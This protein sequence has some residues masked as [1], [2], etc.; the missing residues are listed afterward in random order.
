MLKFF[1]RNEEKDS[2]KTA[3]AVQKSR[4]TWFGKMATLFSRTELDAAAWDELEELLISADVG[5][6]TTFKL[7]ETLRTRIAEE[8]LTDPTEV[9]EALKDEMIYLVDFEDAAETLEAQEKPLVILMVGVNGVGKTTSIAKLTQLYK[10]SGKSVILGAAD[11][12]RAAAIEQLQVWA[13]RLG[14]DLIAHQ[15][16][17]DPGAVAFDTINAAMARGT[18]VVIIDTAGRLHTKFNLMEELKKIQ[19]IMERQ[20]V[21]SHRVLV[22]IDATTGQNGLIQAKAFTEAVECEGVFLAKVDSSS[23]GGIVFGIADELNLP[24]LFIGTGEQ[25]DD[26][27]PFQPHE[28]V[29]GLFSDVIKGQ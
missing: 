11:T 6:A 19:R 5:V 26:V 22:T 14:V 13:D 1:R 3:Q 12:F 23:K 9:M 16:G 7:L 8:R 28:F 15:S 18:D 20:G 2:E 10:E 21:G 24:I 29:E 17:A 4:Q 25:A 27:A